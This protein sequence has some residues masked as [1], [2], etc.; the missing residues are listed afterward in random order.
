MCLVQPDDDDD[1]DEDMWQKLRRHKMVDDWDDIDKM[2]DELKKR[3]LKPQQP[4]A[5]GSLSKLKIDD[6]GC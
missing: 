1:P 4:V 6:E 5:P 2:A 3:G